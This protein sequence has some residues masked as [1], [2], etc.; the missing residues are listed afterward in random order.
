MN[1]KFVKQVFHLLFQFVTCYLKKLFKFPGILEAFFVEINL[2]KN[3]R[4]VLDD[5]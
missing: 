1:F 3:N 2:Y 4:N 5:Q